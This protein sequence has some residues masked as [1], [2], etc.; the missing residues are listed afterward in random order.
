MSPHLIAI[1]LATV[2][3]GYASANPSLISGPSRIMEIMS[4]TSE[5]QRNNPQLASACFNYYDGVFKQD[6][7]LYEDEYNQ[8]V[9]KYEGGH[10]E[11]LKRYDSV[12][13]DLSNS[14]FDAC[15]FLLDCDN[16]NDSQNA[17]SCYAIEGPKYA[18]NLTAIGSSASVFYGS[19]GQEIEQL[20]Y[21]RELCCNTSARNYEIRSGNSYEAFQSCMAGESPVPQDTTTSRPISTTTVPPTT[22]E[23]SPP[24]SSSTAAPITTA[25][26]NQISHIESDERSS[27]NSNHRLARKLESIYRHVV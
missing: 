18:K 19:L 22:Q 10:Q 2:A 27:A 21:T 8:C 1:L 14:T 9:D 4:A 26:P 7:I 15:M 13:W 17:L 25:Q 5:M 23:S 24:A 11:V 6:W 16:K 3:I 20:V 12:V